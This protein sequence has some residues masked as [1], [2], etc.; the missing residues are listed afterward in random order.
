[1]SVQVGESGCVD[2]LLPF[3]FDGR[4]AR[5]A[6][7]DLR[8]GL[9]RMLDQRPY[10]DDLRRLL[11]Q[12]IVAA[13]LLASHLKLDGRINLQFQGDGPVKLLVV[14]VDQ[15]LQLRGMAKA[16][17]EAGGG[18]RELLG[19]G[20]LALMLEPRNGG[21]RYQA[22]VPL[23]GS[24]L[25]EA[26]EGYYI[27]SEQLPTRLRLAAGEGRLV[28]LMLQRM[29][30]HDEQGDRDYWDHLCALFDTLQVEEMLDVGPEVLLRR[31]FHAEPLRLHPARA[32]DLRCSCSH[33]SISTM[34]LALG[35]AE[36]EE[37][38]RAHG[39]IEVTCEFC[40]RRYDFPEVELRELFQAARADAVGGA[41]H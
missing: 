24:T 5:G 38:L 31:L 14:Q 28:G 39:R 3:E 9:S 18:F 10:A 4:G 30:G 36:L 6:L 17:A 27:R 22:L 26:L 40:G 13:P 8:S 29:P 20:R 33:A 37:E 41:R 12:A 16:D 23:E 35:E 21:R 2:A 32:V 25:D 15:H 19:D 34:M 1:V 11:G 7:V